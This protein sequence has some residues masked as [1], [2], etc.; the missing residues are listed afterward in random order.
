MAIICTEITDISLHLSDLVEN[1]TGFRFQV[2]A[3]KMSQF[4]HCSGNTMRAF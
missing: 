1:I 2:V 4:K 3:L